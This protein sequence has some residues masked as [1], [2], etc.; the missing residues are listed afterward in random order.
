[1]YVFDLIVNM[2]NITSMIILLSLFVLFNLL[3]CLFVCLFYFPSYFLLVPRSVD[4]WLLAVVLLKSSFTA[5]S[6]LL[7]YSSL[8][9]MYSPCGVSAYGFFIV[10]FISTLRCT[11]KICCLSY[12]VLAGIWCGTSTNWY[13]TTWSPKNN[14]PW[15]FITAGDIKQMPRYSFVPLFTKQ[16]VI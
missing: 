9:R 4:L 3:V 13:V 14:S 11:G 15:K 5:C 2:H 1:M 12:R 10:L 6:F 8:R 7:W 16:L